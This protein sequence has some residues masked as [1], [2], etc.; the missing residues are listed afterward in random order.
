MR[1][2]GSERQ[3][4][5]SGRSGAR[6]KADGINWCVSKTA[7]RIEQS[8]CMLVRVAILSKSVVFTGKWWSHWIGRDFE[9]L[10]QQQW[11]VGEFVGIEAP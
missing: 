4:G 2:H 3:A 7:W 9:R 6:S 5:F 11:I 1:R 8:S 10:F